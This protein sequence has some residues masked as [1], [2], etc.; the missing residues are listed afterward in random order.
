MPKVVLT[1]EH[2]DFIRA[3]RLKMS[4]KKMAEKFG[5]S[6]TA[7]YNFLKREGLQVPAKVVNK[8]RAEALTGRTSFTAEDDR[9]IKENYLDIPVKRLASMLGRSGTALKIRLGQLNLVIPKEIIEQRKKAFRFKK[10]HISH[11]K[12][13]KMEEFMSPEGIEKSKKTRFKKGNTPPNI[14]YNGYERIS[15]DGYIEVRVKRGVFKLK[16]VHNWE[17]IN[18]PVPKGHCL[19]CIDGDIKNCE[20]SNWRLITLAENMSLNSIWQYPEELRTAIKLTNKITRK[21]K[22]NE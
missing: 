17:K 4:G 8:L 12:G 10:G 9:F 11:N 18:G 7:I 3:N 22:D 16:H 21:L 15:K 13:K 19:R 2:K 6:P 20:P 14:K 5:C 1:E